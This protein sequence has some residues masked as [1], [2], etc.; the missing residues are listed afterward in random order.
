MDLAA[1]PRALLGSTNVADRARGARELAA[2]G[3]TGDLDALLALA[4]GDKATSVRLYAAASVGTLLGRARRDG[5]LSPELG[6]KLFQAATS[7]EPGHAPGLLV[8]L[9]A[10]PGP[11]VLARLGRILRDPRQDV[12]D[13]ALTAF[14]RIALSGHTVD[15]G[16]LEAELIHQL[17]QKRIAT[18]VVVGLARLAADA[19]LEALLKAL[20]EGHRGVRGVGEALELAAQ[21]AAERDVLRTGLFVS[22]GRDA[23]DET[24]AGEAVWI[25]IGAD[26]AFR[27]GV[28]LEIRDGTLGGVRYRL[29]FVGAVAKEP[30][31]AALAGGGLLWKRLDTK[32]ILTFVEDSAGLDPTFAKLLYE[33]LGDDGIGSR[34]RAILALQAG[35]PAEALDQLEALVSIKKP[36]LDLW[37]WV[38]LARKAGGDEAGARVAI[39]VFVTKAPKKH[40][41]RAAAVE[42]QAA[43]GAG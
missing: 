9:A 33:T 43:L 34:G 10:V 13:A 16:P 8:A 40:P 12:R 41:L 4:V 5:E 28:R 3:G 21:R 35:R 15:T 31:R 39:E 27:D 14:T 24:P 17:G 37:Y 18:D 25:G 23:F 11:E 7:V 6:Q 32:G 36:K 2:A 26:G 42:L 1:D 20:S 30:A 22:D 29:V 38:A 19:G